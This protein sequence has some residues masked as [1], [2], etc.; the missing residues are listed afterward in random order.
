[1][2]PKKTKHDV[3]TEEEFAHH[4]FY[5]PVFI[6]L[7]KYWQHRGL[8]PHEINVLD[9][10]CGRGRDTLWLLERGYNVY[11]VDIDPEPIQNGLAL[12]RQ[13]GYGEERLRMADL[14]ARTD[15]PDG[16]FHF[17]YSNQSFEHS[18]NLEQI[19]AEL[20][21]VTAPDGAGLHV[22]PPDRG[23]REGHVLMPFVHWLPKTRL[24]YPLVRLCVGLG[25]EP[26]WR[27][28]EGWTGRQKA[29]RY[30]EYLNHNTYYRKLGDVFG[31]FRQAGFEVRSETIHHPEVQAHRLV[32]PLARARLTRP[33]IDFLLNH[34]VRVELHIHKV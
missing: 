19:A 28:L 20:A 15:F 1:M 11:G 17:S 25:M 22:Y 8:R 9:W 21:R 2:N 34:M 24:R 16:Y 7:E 23:I 33:V 13:K 18:A 5:R 3:L 10:G 14:S 31:L 6:A 26:R 32:G 29:E 12:F 30:Y 27:E 4:R